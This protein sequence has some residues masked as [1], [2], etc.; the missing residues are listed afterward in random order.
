[1]QEKIKRGR[2]L[3]TKKEKK[4]GN[5]KQALKEGACCE[6]DYVE[7]KFLLDSACFLGGREL[8]ESEKCRFSNQKYYMY[9]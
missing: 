1:M 6:E 7:R 9:T 8:V 3:K 5:R 4:R 2:S